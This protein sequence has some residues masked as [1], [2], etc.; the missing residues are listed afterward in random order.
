MFAPHPTGVRSH[1]GP[2]VCFENHH[3]YSFLMLA[4]QCLLK[5]APLS[6]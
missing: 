1:F 4:G 2:S 5:R 6:R 3:R